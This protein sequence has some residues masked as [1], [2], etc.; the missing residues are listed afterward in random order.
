MA[1]FDAWCC[2]MISCP[3][4]MRSSQ[5]PRWR[6]A[7]RP[8][9]PCMRLGML[10]PPN[11]IQEHPKRHVLALGRDTCPANWRRYCSLNVGPVICPRTWLSQSRRHCPS[12]ARKRQSCCEGGPGCTAF[13]SRHHHA[14]GWFGSLMRGSPSPLSLLCWPRHPAI[15]IQSRRRVQRGCKWAD[16]EVFSCLPPMTRQHWE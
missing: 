7:F 2:D 11:C 16:G 13:Q 12:A 4:R 15:V 3:T 10:Q 9:L 14:D 5:Y 8:T 1:G 6:L